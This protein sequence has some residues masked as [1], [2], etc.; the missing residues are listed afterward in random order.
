[1]RITKPEIYRSFLFSLFFP[2]PDKILT[3]IKRALSDSILSFKAEQPFVVRIRNCRYTGFGCN[4][5]ASFALLSFPSSIHLFL[6][7]TYTFKMTIYRCSAFNRFFFLSL[8][9]FY[10][11]FSLP[12]NLTSNFDV[13]KKE[14]DFK[15]YFNKYDFQTANLDQGQV[16]R[17]KN[18]V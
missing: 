5:V 16:S 11:F 10:L 4:S 8:S 7:L 6:T 18:I 9:F 17:T 1:M 2:H 13:I 12:Q 15:L 14:L 3:G